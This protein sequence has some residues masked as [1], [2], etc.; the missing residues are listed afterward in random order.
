ML[1]QIKRLQKA[2]A[3]FGRPVTLNLYSEGNPADFRVFA[4]AGCNLHISEDAFESFHNMVAADILLGAYSTFSYVAGTLSEGIVID[5]RRR[6][7]RLTSWIGRR[8]NRDIPI[9]RLRRAM[10]SRLGW[11]Q[12]CAYHVRRCWQALSR[13]RAD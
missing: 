3:P 5:R 6:V 9:A 12:R 1:R 10:L 13:R 4:D 7:P 8:K 11:Q 2:L